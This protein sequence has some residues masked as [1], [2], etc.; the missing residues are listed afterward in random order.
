MPLYLFF[1]IVKLPFPKSMSMCEKKL[2]NILKLF[3]Y[4]R[5]WRGEIVWNTLLPE[6][7]ELRYCFCDRSSTEALKWPLQFFGRKILNSVTDCRKEIIVPE[8]NV[9]LIFSKK[10]R[11]KKRSFLA[12]PLKMMWQSSLVKQGHQPVSSW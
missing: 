4:L 5:D 9:S 12:K 2:Q 6:T 7:N 3:D 1:L 10:F 8:N 11:E